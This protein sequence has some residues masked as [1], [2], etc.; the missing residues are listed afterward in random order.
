ME[1]G[2]DRQIHLG[3]AAREEQDAIFLDELKDHAARL[4]NVTLV[5]LFSDEGNFARVD[6]MKQKLPDPLNTYDYFMC[7]P[8]PM[9][10]GIMAD[11]KQEG[12]SRN[13]IHTEAFEFR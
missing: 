6:M 11:L 3:Y 7:G 9:M 12:V 1:E 2:D 4:G 13:K 5:P 8:S 10:N